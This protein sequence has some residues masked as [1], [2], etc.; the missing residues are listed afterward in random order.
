MRNFAKYKN[1]AELCQPT[2]V[3]LHWD[4]QNDT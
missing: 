2:E 4:V 1:E 3:I